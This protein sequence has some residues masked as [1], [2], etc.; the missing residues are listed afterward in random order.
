VRH[1]GDVITIQN[2]VDEL[3]EDYDIHTERIEE[4][5]RKE[6]SRSCPS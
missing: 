2:T 4:W 3:I 5:V 6:N 1:K